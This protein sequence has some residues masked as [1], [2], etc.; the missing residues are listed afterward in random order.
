[1]ITK[2]LPQLNCRLPQNLLIELCLSV[3]HL[4]AKA[5]VGA[6]V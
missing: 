5:D 2:A 4:D 6:Y 3:A 1:M